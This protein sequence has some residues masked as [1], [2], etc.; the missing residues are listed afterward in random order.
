MKKI[1]VFFAMLFFCFVVTICQAAPNNE[2]AL[3]GITLGMSKNSVKNIYGEPKQLE[4]KHNRD[5]CMYGDSFVLHFF[6][7][8]VTSMEIDDN[9]GV[10]MTAGFT[11]G[12]DLRELV[13]YFG[14]NYGLSPDYREYDDM[15]YADFLYFYPDK[16]AVILRVGYDDD[17]KICYIRIQATGVST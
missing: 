3:G 1:G 16:S 14:Q 17:Y 7:G 2:F 5:I 6:N 11:V 12:S 4:D 13:K 10:K 15:Y 8:Y 9:N